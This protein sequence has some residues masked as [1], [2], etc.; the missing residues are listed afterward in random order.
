MLYWYRL[1][2]RCASGAGYDKDRRDW[3]SVCNDKRIPVPNEIYAHHPFLERALE[4]R[5]NGAIY[6]CAVCGN[7]EESDH[8]E[9]CANADRDAV[10]EMI[11]FLADR[12]GPERTAAMFTRVA[13][14]EAA[15]EGEAES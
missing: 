9:G 4:E 7:D 10:T 5:E 14:R 13:E 3:C 15:G 1:C 8:E 12:I 11:E 6:I 2:C